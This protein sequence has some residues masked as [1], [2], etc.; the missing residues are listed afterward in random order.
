MAF[1][2]TTDEVIE[3][4]DLSGKTAVIT[5]ATTGLGQETARTLAAAGA[6]VVVCGRTEEKCDAAMATIRESVPG[7]SLESQTF[8]LGDLATVRTGAD[9]L[10]ARHD[11]I[12]LLINNA[13]VMF[14]PEGQTVDG[15]ETQFG[16][17]HLGHFVLTNRLLPAVKAAAPSRIVNLSSA[18]HFT[19]DVIWDDPNFATTEYDKFNAYGQ[20][21][22]SN[23]LFSVEL[24]RRHGSDGVRANAVHPGMIMTELARHMGPDDLTE[25]GERAAK[26]SGPGLPEFKSL[27]QG[28]ATSVWVAV[29][30]EMTDVGGTYCEDA[31]VS[32]PAPYALDGDA[33]ARLWAMSEE[34]VGESF[35]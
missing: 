1:E 10:L 12:D 32:T 14:T 11:R 2:T 22:T 35:S 27:E 19:S 8:D 21:K 9:A 25:L 17:N 31:S 20:S 15:F 33:A 24:D 29:A 30:D 34:L 26:R 16:T 6:H 7:A 13:G 18:G 28:A 23:I 4:V 5:G 3:G